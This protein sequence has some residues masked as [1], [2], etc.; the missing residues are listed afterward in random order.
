[1]TPAASIRKVVITKREIIP[2]TQLLGY[3]SP[4]AKV[5]Y[6]LGSVEVSRV[7]AAIKW[8]GGTCLL[9][10]AIWFLLASEQIIQWFRE[11]Q[12][13]KVLST[14]DDIWRSRWFGR[15]LLAI[16]R[17]LLAISAIFIV[18]GWRYPFLPGYAITAIAV[19][20]GIMALRSD[21][22]GPERSLWFIVL[23]VFAVMEIR[24]IKHEHDDQEVKFQTTATG[25]QQAISELQ[26]T[27]QEGRAHFDTTMDKFSTVEALQKENAALQKSGVETISQRQ[28][29][30][31]SDTSLAEHLK[32]IA[33]QIRDVE[34][35]YRYKDKE[36]SN[37]YYDHAQRGGLKKE[38]REK[39]FN[40]EATARQKLAEWRD[41]QVKQ[42]FDQA[43][44]LYKEARYRLDINLPTFDERRG[45]VSGKADYVL[46]RVEQ[47]ESAAQALIA[48]E[49]AK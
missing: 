1:M 41:D 46:T 9:I 13:K 18:I 39:F 45:I 19:V 29:R 15:A 30:E 7:W 34:S 28:L 12:P 8:V 48:N 49:G 44:P 2:F 4:Q 31:M 25:L 6:D 17:A 33:E 20:A 10:V 40:D 16:S 42:K 21:M 37:I 47:L 26:T 14:L 32:R 35:S 38:E 3:N 43:D 11:G 24:A 23:L 27:I 36:I 22:S 5:A